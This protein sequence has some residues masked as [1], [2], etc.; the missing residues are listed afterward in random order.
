MDPRPGPPPTD[1]TYTWENAWSRTW[2][3]HRRDRHMRKCWITDVTDKYYGQVLWTSQTWQTS[4][5]DKYYGHH[6]PW[7]TST[8]GITDRDRQVLWTSQTVRDKYYVLNNIDTKESMRYNQQNKHQ[9]CKQNSYFVF[10]I[11]IPQGLRWQAFNTMIEQEWA[12]SST[13]YRFYR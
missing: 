5:M 2:Q 4:T 12:R 3:T 6:R 13:L 11:L 9:Y 10:H 7:Q 1:V 8:M